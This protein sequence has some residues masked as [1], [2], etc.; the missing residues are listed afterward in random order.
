MVDFVDT[1]NTG[2]FDSFAVVCA[3]YGGGCEL[4]RLTDQPLS[5]LRVQ[6]FSTIDSC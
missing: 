6:D 1:F 4:A 2:R 5:R 3:V